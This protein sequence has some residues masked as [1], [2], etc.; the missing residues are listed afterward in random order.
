MAYLDPAEAFAHFRDRTIEGI[1]S[2]F[3]IKGKFQTLNLKSIEVK[4]SGKVGGKA[5]FPAVVVDGVLRDGAAADE[6]I[7]EVKL[8]GAA[9]DDGEIGADKSDEADLSDDGG[10][11]GIERFDVEA[12]GGGEGHVT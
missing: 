3:P 9:V 2:H 6:L 12:D 5:A 11:G 4:E 8:D 1:Q 10:V 7:E